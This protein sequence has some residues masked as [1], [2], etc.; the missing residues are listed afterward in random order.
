VPDPARALRR[1]WE[2]LLAAEDESR[3][4]FQGL[5]LSLA[6][7]AGHGDSG[8]EAVR[9][10]LGPVAAAL[11]ADWDARRRDQAAT[12]VV[13]VVR[14]LLLDRLATGEADRVDGAFER[15]AEL[16]GPVFDPT[17]TPGASPGTE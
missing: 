1:L 9:Q 16:V 14:G 6:D 4:L 11:P 15:F 17:C 13:A 7:P 10:F 3:L 8:R 2:Y 12:L 5:G